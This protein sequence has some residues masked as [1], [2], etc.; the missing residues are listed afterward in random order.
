MNYETFS[1]RQHKL[2]WMRSKSVVTPKIH[3]IYH[4]MKKMHD[5]EKEKGFLLLY[6]NKCYYD[7]I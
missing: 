6:W 3:I 1:I 4:K 2:Y 5:A 7:R